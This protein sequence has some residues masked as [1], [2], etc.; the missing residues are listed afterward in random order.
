MTM[1]PPTRA[2]L[3]LTLL[4]V[5]EAYRLQRDQP[6][7]RQSAGAGLLEAYLRYGGNAEHKLVVTAEADAAWFHQQAKRWDPKARTLAMGIDSWGDAATASGAILLSGP[8]LDEWA[9]KRMP[10]GDG[11]YSLV[12][13]V[14]TL[15]SRQVQF[16][17]GQFATAPIRPWDALICTS[18]ASK[19]VVEGFLD[20]QEDWLKQRLGA[21]LFERPQLPV[22]PLGVHAETWTP[23]GG[24]QTA[25][26][27][28]RSQLNLPADAQV[29]LLAGR[30]DILTKFHPG[31]LLRTLGELHDHELPKLHVVIYGE[32]PNTGMEQL[33]KQGLKD[34]A[35]KLPVH[36]VPGRE[37]NMAGPVRWA[38]DLFVSL[39]DNPQETFGIT[40]L[41]AMAAELPC[42]VSDWDGYR[43]TVTDD[44]G[45]RIPT[46]MVEGLGTNESKGL[47]NETLRYDQAVGLIS[48]GVS[49]DLKALH[50]ALIG[51]L[52]NPQK[53]QTMGAAARKRATNHYAW[54]IVISQWK[55]LL[56]ELKHKR[57]LAKK[58]GRT[59][60]HGLP[61]WLPPIAE[62]Y[63][64]Y[65]TSIQ[66]SISNEEIA[67]RSDLLEAQVRT[68]GAFD[69][70]D[71]GLQHEL[72][73]AQEGGPA[74]NARLQ[75]WLLKQGLLNQHPRD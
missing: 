69:H 43:D 8:G 24:K 2:P 35:P 42:L 67:Q 48:Q 4:M 31:P 23:P 22:I 60:T 75:G 41:E 70:W 46:T 65:S 52:Q 7:G 64:D 25:K 32:A 27:A 72:G 29:V 17:L 55:Q 36:W 28:A 3:P 63:A 15:C 13:L 66:S 57:L 19:A 1:E 14:H 16:G 50:Q 18:T 68:E 58:Q 54:P 37:E 51:L 62:G 30:L 71:S 56:Q 39:P 5:M 44:V 26:A 61:H 73:I 53:L 10:W 74:T 47:L 49:V 45:L 34:C 21:H 20:R 40:P 9:W 11:A 59:M 6:L 38:S 12:G 33:W